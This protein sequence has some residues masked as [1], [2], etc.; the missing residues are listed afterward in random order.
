MP[1]T[2]PPERVSTSGQV[3]V[4]LDAAEPAGGAPDAHAGVLARI[5]ATSATRP[6]SPLEFYPLVPHITHMHST[7]PAPLT[8]VRREKFA[9]AIASGM[10]VVDAY[11]EAGFRKDDGN[12]SRL[13][14]EPVIRRR[15]REIQLEN[16]AMSLLSREQALGIL[17][18]IVI[19]PVSEVG[20]NSPL[21][22]E[23]VET[24][25][26]TGTCVKVRMPSKIEA[27]RLLGKWNGW[28]QGSVAD[29]DAA[30]ALGGVAELVQ[31]IRARGRIGS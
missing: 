2:T 28:E 8:S 6:Q 4:T 10:A 17:A 5:R 14:S 15:V 18:E 19:T 7:A 1:A 13:L 23:Y 25:T 9:R 26:E 12:A 11:Q 21:A 22:Q 30:K 29:R 20:A 3:G 16:N 27:L 31:R 24:M